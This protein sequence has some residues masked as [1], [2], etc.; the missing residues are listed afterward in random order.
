ME[1]SAADLFEPQN[2]RGAEQV[3]KRDSIMNARETDWMEWQAGYVCRALLMPVS[4]LRKL[5]AASS[6]RMKYLAHWASPRHEAP[7]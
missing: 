4:P 6:R 3:C 2:V 7:S 1:P 5:W